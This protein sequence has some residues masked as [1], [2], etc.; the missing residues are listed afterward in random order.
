MMDSVARLYTDSAGLYSDAARTSPTRTGPLPELATAHNI[1]SDTGPVWL[2]D[3]EGIQQCGQTVG[4]PIVEQRITILCSQ[5]KNARI[6]FQNVIRRVISVS[7]IRIRSACSNSHCLFV[8]QFNVLLEKSNV[9]P[10][11]TV[12]GLMA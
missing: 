5:A 1:V 6:T 10:V 4:D 7:E 2:A 8:R 9:R 11:H 3:N 12:N